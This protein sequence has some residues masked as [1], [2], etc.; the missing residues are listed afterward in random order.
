MQNLN[1]ESENQA[2]YVKK[3]RKWLKNMEKDKSP[4]IDR[5]LA[6]LWNT[7]IINWASRLHLQQNLVDFQ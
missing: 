2:S 5:I 4:D 3:S 7:I 6:E 1:V